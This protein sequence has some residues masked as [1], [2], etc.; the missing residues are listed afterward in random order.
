MHRRWAG[1]QLYTSHFILLPS[2]FPT[3]LLPRHT[4]TIGASSGQPPPALAIFARAPTAGKAKTRLIRLLGCR[5]AAE[6]HAALISDA[7]R[8]VNGLTGRVARYLFLAGRSLPVFPALSHYRLGRQRGADLG[9]R[10]AQGFRQLLR[11]HTA[12]VVIGTD[13]PT[14]PPRILRQAFRELRFCDA[15]LGPCPDGGYYLIGLRRLAVAALSERP[16]LAGIRNRRYRSRMMAGIFDGVRWGSAAAFR[17]TLQNL[18]R[19]NFSCSILEPFADIDHP[20]DI[21]RLRRELARSAAVRRLAPAAWRFLKEYR[22]LR[23]GRLGAP[24]AESRK[25]KINKV[26]KTAPGQSWT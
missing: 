6:F 19:R 20:R 3:A 24:R 8:K 18:L 22:S 16:G 15:V 4:P 25:L 17:D 26:T 1:P 21:R 10:L 5:G 12:A 11:R 2:R 13:S 7:I 9:K 14:F 23:P